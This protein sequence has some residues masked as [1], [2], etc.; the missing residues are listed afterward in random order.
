MSVKPN[1]AHVSNLPKNT[2]RLNF[3]AVKINV[4]IF[5]KITLFLN[6]SMTLVY[7]AHNIKYGN[8]SKR[9]FTLQLPSAL[10]K[11]MLV[12]NCTTSYVWE[13]VSSGQQAIL[14]FLLFFPLCY[15]IKTGICAFQVAL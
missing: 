6:T 2:E 13:L 15:Y 11:V 5:P 4:V 9:S 14:L 12:L 3:A 8:C 7:I 10:L 1:T